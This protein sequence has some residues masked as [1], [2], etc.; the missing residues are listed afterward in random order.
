MKN[1]IHTLFLSLV[2]A[3]CG[4]T[5]QSNMNKTPNQ[6]TNTLTGQI[7]KEEFSDKGGR[8]SGVYEYYLRCSVQDYFIKFCESTVTKKEIDALKLGEF[9]TIKVEAKIIDGNW[10]ICPND[11]DLMQSRVGE[12]V[13]IYKIVL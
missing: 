13:V 9:D 11:P 3:A 6:D 4:T 12:Y 10:D 5:K 8:S 7:V 2:I 1:I